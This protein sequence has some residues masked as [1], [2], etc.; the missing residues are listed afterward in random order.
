MYDDPIQLCRHGLISP[1]IA[2]SRLLLAG[3]DLSVIADR[4]A[5]LP[6][7]RDLLVARAA[8]IADLA[9]IGHDSDHAGPTDVATIAAF[10][11]RAVARQPE[12]SVAFYCLGD[13]ALLAAASAEIVG[14]L[15][16]RRLIGPATDMLDLG[17]GIG[18]VAQALAPH[19]RSVIGLDI[20]SGMI[21]RAMV[22]CGHL[23][24]M[25]YLRGNGRDLDGV[26]TASL[27]LVL[28]VDAFP[29]VVQLGHD[30]A[31]RHIAEAARV[32]RPGGTLALLNLSYGPETIADLQRWAGPAS[33][34]VRIAGVRPFCLW[35]ATVFTLE[36]Q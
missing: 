34:H 10:F 13:P 12:A 21:E 29:Y 9:A 8:V 24:N 19:C 6:P 32:L 20:S 28:A 27:D 1:E 16:D 31:Q 23:P 4:V 18:R 30:A 15:A 5:D 2:L 35:D 25:R 36:R 7:L 33:W 14:W 22:R 17:C 11:D 3:A 26:D